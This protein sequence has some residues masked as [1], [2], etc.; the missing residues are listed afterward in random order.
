MDGHYYLYEKK[1]LSSFR[2][3]DKFGAAEFVFLQ[4]IGLIV[5][6]VLAHLGAF[7]LLDHGYG[8]FWFAL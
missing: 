7:I 8:P 1:V 4:I 6:P 3:F 2:F 5:R